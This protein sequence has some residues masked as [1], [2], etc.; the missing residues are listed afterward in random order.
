MAD[1]AKQGQDG[2]GQAPGDQAATTTQL[3]AQFTKEWADA[4]R[5]HCIEVL[6][7]AIPKSRRMEF[8]GE[9]N[10]ALLFISAAKTVAPSVPGSAD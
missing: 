1:E 5:D 4:V 3:P 2:Q 6:F 9:Y 7:N 10:D 8:I